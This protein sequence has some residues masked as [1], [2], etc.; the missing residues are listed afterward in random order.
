[1][2]KAIFIDFQKLHNYSVVSHKP[3]SSFPRIHIR[4]NSLFQADNFPPPHN[5]IG[6]SPWLLPTFP[7]SEAPGIAPD[8]PPCSHHQQSHNVQ[9]Q[10]PADKQSKVSMELSHS[11]GQWPRTWSSIGAV[12]RQPQARAHLASLRPTGSMGTAR[13][14]SPQARHWSLSD[15]SVPMNGTR[16]TTTCPTGCNRQWRA[17]MLW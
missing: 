15:K 7:L 17:K 4:T 10:L 14:M 5:S 12:L 9:R 6:F 11:R 16:G 3:F 8:Q 1:M 2:T 13:G